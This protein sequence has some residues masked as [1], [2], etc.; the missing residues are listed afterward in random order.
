MDLKRFGIEHVKGAIAAEKFYGHWN[1][2]QH[3]VDY[4]SE[5]ADMMLRRCLPAM[6]RVLE[7][8][9]IGGAGGAGFLKQP[10]NANGMGRAEM[11]DRPGNRSFP[12]PLGGA[13]IT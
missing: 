6:R 9:L 5:F 10:R 11:T 3:L 7:Y 1:R 4:F 13:V 8:G 2:L 12:L